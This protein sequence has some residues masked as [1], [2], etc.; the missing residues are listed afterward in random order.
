MTAKQ[1]KVIPSQRLR[2]ELFPLTTQSSSTAAG[3]A[4]K[5]RNE[6]PRARAL[7]SDSALPHYG[8]ANRTDLSWS[9]LMDDVEDL[10]AGTLNCQAANGLGLR[11]SSLH[12]YEMQ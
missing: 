1:P 2:L 4:M 9:R 7:A 6:Y 8:Q 5:R 11:R 12:S 3:L 10:N